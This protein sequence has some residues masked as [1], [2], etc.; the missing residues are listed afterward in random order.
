MSASCTTRRQTN[1]ARTATQQL[2]GTVAIDRAL[3]ALAWPDLDGRSVIVEVFSAADQVDQSYLKGSAE[4]LLA[5]KGAEVVRD[6]EKAELV[7][8]LLAEALGTDQVDILL[9]TPR[10][11]SFLVTIPEMALYKLERQEGFAR[12]TYVLTHGDG[13]FVFRSEP[14]QS[15]TFA[16]SRRILFLGKHETDVGRYEGDD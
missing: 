13:E 7:L 11:E 6:R 14:S 10:L 9:G 3:T 2:L 16:Q 1:T 4:A 8:T 15:E 5:E 12:V